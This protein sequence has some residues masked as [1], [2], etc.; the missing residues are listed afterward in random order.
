MVLMKAIP[1]V[2]N[3]SCF[4]GHLKLLE[5]TCPP[6]SSPL[7]LFVFTP[8]LPILFFQC[9]LVQPLRE[10]DCKLMQDETKL[11]FFSP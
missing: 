4:F 6:L 5:K 3:R 2:W 8:V 1:A 9:R 7:L 10:P 11:F